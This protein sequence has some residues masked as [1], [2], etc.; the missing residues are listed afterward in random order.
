VLY[1]CHDAEFGKG[2]LYHVGKLRFQQEA[3]AVIRVK[4]HTVKEGWVRDA[5]FT[6]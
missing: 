4:C 3:I 6:H 2:V 5:P 1:D